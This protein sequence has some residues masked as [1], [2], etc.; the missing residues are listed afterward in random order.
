MIRKD[1]ERFV[2]DQCKK[3]EENA[4]ANSTRELFNSMWSL[5]KK[6]GRTVNTIKDEAVLILCDGEHVKDRWRFKVY[7]KNKNLNTYDIH[8]NKVKFSHHQPLRTLKKPL[9]N[10]RLAKAPE[11]T[12]YC[13]NDKEWRRARAEVPPKTLHMHSA[14]NKMD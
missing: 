3:I 12:K 13:W 7:K 10:S 9:K 8:S 14:C 1:K 6:R 4:M 5:T 2:E 11:M